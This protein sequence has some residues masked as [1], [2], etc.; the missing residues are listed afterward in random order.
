MTS[1]ANMAHLERDETRDNFNNFNYTAEEASKP[2]RRSS[3]IRDKPLFVGLKQRRYGPGAKNSTEAGNSGSDSSASSGT[4]TRTAD[5]II[6]QHKLAREERKRANLAVGLGEAFGRTDENGGFIPKTTAAP[7]DVQR[8]PASASIIPESRIPRAKTFSANTSIDAGGISSSPP[9][10]ESYREMYMRQEREKRSGLSRNTPSPADSESDFTGPRQGSPSPAPLIRERTSRGRESEGGRSGTS[11]TTG[12]P[13]QDGANGHTRKLSR[14]TIGQMLA[15]PPLFVRKEVGSRVS[16]TTKLLA[17]KTSKENFIDTPQYAETRV[18]EMTRVLT[19][20]T[21]TNFDDIPEPPMRI[22]QTWGARSRVKSGWMAKILTPDPSLEI[23]DLQLVGDADLQQMNPNVPL[24][25]IEDASSIM[26]TPP[27]SRPNSAH[28]TNTSPEKG[29]AWDADV[30]FTG[31]SLQISTSPQLRVRSAKLDEIREREIQSLTARAVA[32]NR[33][34]EIRE[35]NSEERSV[36]SESSRWNERETTSAPKPEEE[37]DQEEVYHERTILEEE[38]YPIPGTPI[39]VFPKG[40][41]RFQ[42]GRTSPDPPESP[43]ATLRALARILSPKSST[44]VITDDE[45]E[46]DNEKSEKPGKKGPTRKEPKKVGRNEEAIDKQDVKDKSASTEVAEEMHEEQLPRGRSSDKLSEKAKGKAAEIIT[47]NGLDVDVDTKRHSRTST[48]PKSD[49]DPEERI[50]AEAKL[51][52][53]QDNRSERNS[54]RAPSRSPSP[55]PSDEG[56]FDQTP[57]PKADPLSLPTPKVTGAYIETPAPTMRVSRQARS[58]SLSSSPVSEVADFGFATSGIRRT[59]S[60]SK[61]ADSSTEDRNERRSRSITSQNTTTRREATQSQ[62]RTIDPRPQPLI[63]SNP[64]PTFRETLRRLEMEGGYEDSTIDDFEA[65]LEEDA[66]ATADINNKNT[67]EPLLETMFDERG[68]PLSQREIERR[69]E[70]MMLDKMN[71]HLKNTSSSIRDARQGIERLEYQ[72]SSTPWP[73]VENN[74]ENL[75]IK[76]PVPQLWI[77]NPPSENPR[78]LESRRNWKFTWFGLILAI[79]A[80]WFLAE[81]MMCGVYCHPKQSTHNDW[82][83]SDPFFP[84]AIPTKLDHWTGE[85]VSRSWNALDTKLG[86]PKR[87]TARP[88]GASDWWLGRDGPIGIIRDKR[89]DGFYD[90]EL[91]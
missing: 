47:S 74:D 54:I 14:E 22:P 65:L 25:T 71:K 21:S 45:D 68:L 56:N 84:W 3:L 49:V 7:I 41:Y 23:K 72:V 34:E 2:A 87:R 77:R 42:N 90:D 16:E 86:P 6:R 57:R 64:P 52:E 13:S 58:T 51:F 59:Q 5:E 91:V 38:G 76:I 46:V 82:H 39:W 60:S 40:S 11:S 67:Q 55:S 63:N 81:S 61:I 33:L 24:S 69:L 70:R 36:L 48:P 75:Y 43:G 18:Q 32:T 89:I 80:A 26:P 30:D 66:T 79:F 78:Q 83:P 9:K 1:S 8:E 10:M 29:N 37:Q 35:R 17:R 20:K 88:L 50:T 28:P 19:K 62:S 4:Q 53:L 31:Q 27:S 44:V 12:P 73:T 15:R 85:I